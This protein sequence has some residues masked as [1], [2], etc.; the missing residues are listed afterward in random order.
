MHAIVARVLLEACVAAGD[1]RAGLAAADR[2]LDPDDRVRV[3]EPETRRLRGEFLGRLG[4]PAGEVEAEL[5]LALRVARRQGARMPALRAAASLLRQRLDRGDRERADEARE[6]LAAIA[7]E[8]PDA[9]DTHD[10]R[11]ANALLSGV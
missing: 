7:G 10:L 1:A 3:W 11:D 2:A 5:E 4:A 8:L 9:R 6:R